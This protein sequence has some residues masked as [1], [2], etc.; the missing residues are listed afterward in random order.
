MGGTAAG[1]TTGR[2]NAT[3]VTANDLLLAY[4]GKPALRVD[5]LEIPAGG[6]VALVGPNGSGKS[7][8]L[9]AISGVLRPSSGRLRVFGDRPD[10]ARRH[11]AYV[12]QS[13]TAVAL[14]VTVRDV[15][16]MGRYANRG[17][18]R[19]LTA[20]DHNA[21]SSMLERL[22]IEQLAGAQLRDLSVGQ[23][24]RVLVAQGLAQQAPMLLLDEPLTGLDVVSQQ[25]IVEVIET[26]RR[27][28]RTVLVATH[29]L[30][31][32]QRA[33]FVV[34]LAGRVVCAGPPA[35]ALRTRFLQ[36]AYAGRLLN[37]GDAGS[38]LDDHAHGPTDA[39]HAGASARP[40]GDSPA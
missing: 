31:E 32:A 15:V 1:H 34:L 6:V 38:L 5:R 36:D 13:A 37:L 23:R 8:L 40:E 18:W 20:E 9:S 26:E 25:R 24:Q 39:E 19:R 33:D 35:D 27:S 2:P 10:A 3:A 28:R 4:D 7:T 29:D 14:P 30:R 11:V 17:L 22:E 12:L 16:A 21:V